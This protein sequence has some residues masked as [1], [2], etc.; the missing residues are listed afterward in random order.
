MSKSSNKQARYDRLNKRYGVKY[1][2]DGKA[3]AHI[4]SSAISGGKTKEDIIA[5]CNDK[6]TRNQQTI[7]RLTAENE[8]YTKTRIWLENATEEQYTDITNPKPGK[9]EYGEDT[10]TQES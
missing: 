7:A 8:R 3:V 6:I 5:H 2:I 1:G 10:S 4:R 9:E